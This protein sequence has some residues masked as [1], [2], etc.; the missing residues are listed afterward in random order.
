[1][2]GAAPFLEP[3]PNR[4]GPGARSALAGERFVFGSQR[5]VY[6]RSVEPTALRGTITGSRMASEHGPRGL[7]RPSGAFYFATRARVARRRA[8]PLPDH[9]RGKGAPAALPAPARAVLDPYPAPYPVSRID[10]AG[11]DKR[12]ASLP[13]TGATVAR[14]RSCPGTSRP[15]RS[16]SSW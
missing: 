3:P 14:G 1:M 2:P 7:V 10:K 12:L 4:G 13:E 9:P 11:S 16:P 5:I 6:H 8:E 15:R